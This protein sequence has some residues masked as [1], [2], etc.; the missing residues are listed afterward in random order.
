MGEA[1]ENEWACVG[2]QPTRWSLGVVASGRL[3]HCV[4][5]VE[6]QAD[7][8]WR[9]W[10]AHPQSCRGIVDGVAPSR[11]TAEAEVERMRGAAMSEGD[12]DQ[13]KQTRRN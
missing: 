11:V 6:R 13:C 8:S 9:W 7:G 10:S 12:R 2:H 5:S 1:N 4:G 3:F